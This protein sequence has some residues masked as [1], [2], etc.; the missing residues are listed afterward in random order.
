MV[1]QI[2]HWGLA[3]RPF[4]MTRDARFFF[5]SEGHAEA[6]ARMR[7]LVQDGAFGFGM[8]SG[9]IGCGKTY[10]ASVF[11][12]TL[13][14]RRFTPVFLEN[15]NLGFSCVLDQIN[16]SLGDR[17][18]C[19]IPPSRYQL[20]TEFRHL[21]A[22][23][24]LARGAHLVLVLDEAQEL[25]DEDL[26]ELR[27]LTN[28]I[29]SRRGVLTIVLVGQPDLRERVRAMRAVD[30]RIGLR[31]HL[32]LLSEADVGAYVAHRLRAAGHPSGH[33]FTNEAV[34]VLAD[35][36]AGMPREI[37]RLAKLSLFSAASRGL[38]FVS[39]DEVRAI[40]ADAA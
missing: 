36:S 21:L 5:R 14:P 8:L 11:A 23:R 16:C 3:E 37:N 40:A 32:G 39:A 10:T 19:G 30:T 34:A 26:S 1:E 33:V 38:R 29:G 17:R 6:L 7:F 15:A 22:A 27:C 31:Y 13:D 28:A 20:L 25:S 12:A 4:E 24:V 9:E 2:R 18:S 35:S